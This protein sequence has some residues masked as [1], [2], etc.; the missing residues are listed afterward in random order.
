MR[1]RGRGREGKGREKKM[2]KEINF[3]ES[4]SCTQIYSTILHTA[5]LIPSKTKAT[6][7]NSVAL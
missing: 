1:K 4:T 2:E 5:N 3:L 6:T 7:T